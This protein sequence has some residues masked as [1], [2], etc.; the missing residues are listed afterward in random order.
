MPARHDIWL[1]NRSIL[2]DH[3]KIGVEHKLRDKSRL[4]TALYCNEMIR[5]AGLYKCR[6]LRLYQ[7]SRQQATPFI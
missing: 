5:T 1:I 3:L 6:N 2:R 7:A 4:K